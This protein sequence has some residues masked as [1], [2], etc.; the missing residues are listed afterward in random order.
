MKVGPDIDVL[1]RARLA[2]ADDLVLELVHCL[3]SVEREEPIYKSLEV[4]A[5]RKAGYFLQELLPDLLVLRQ[6][7]RVLGV[8]RFEG[9]FDVLQHAAFLETM[10]PLV[11]GRLQ[12]GLHLMRPLQ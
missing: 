12:V 9:R 6:L 10:L 1:G 8:E 2:S 4:I 3:L 7:R 5:S 11:A